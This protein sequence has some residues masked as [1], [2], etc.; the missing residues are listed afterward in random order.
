MFKNIEAFYKANHFK[1]IEDKSE[2]SLRP[3]KSF[4]KDVENCISKFKTFYIENEYRTINDERLTIVIGDVDTNTRSQNL[5]VMRE[6]GFLVEIDTP[7]E[8]GAK[9]K[10]TDSFAEFVDS[11]MSP[12]DVVFEKFR[13]LSS[14][15]NFTMY[16][17]LLLCTLR[18]AYVYGQVM[19]FR[20]SIDKFKADVPDE[21]KRY[22][23]RK[24][25]HDIYGYSG[26]DKQIT[27]DVYSPNLSYMS[28]AELENLGLLI[29][30]TQKIDNMNN[31]VLTKKGY[32][33]LQHIDANLGSVPST[34]VMSGNEY[35]RAAQYLRS[36]VSETG[37]DIPSKKDD[38]ESVLSEFNAKFS[39][40]TLAALPDEDILNYIFYTLGDNLESLCC[41]LEMNKEC[42]NHFG[43]IS[44]GSAYKFGLF[45]KQKT[46]EWTTGSPQKSQVLTEDEALELGCKIRDALVTAANIVKNATLDT[47]EDY[48]R[49]DD[50]LWEKVG[51]PYCNWGW[52]HKYLS[53]VCPDKLS[54]YH[55]SDWQRHVLYALKIKPSEKYFAR[56]GQLAMI[57][58]YAGWYYSEFKDVLVERFGSEILQF[59]RIGTSDDEQNY[60]SEWSQK[61]VFGIGWRDIGP[62]D[63]YVAGEGLDKGAIADALKEKFGYQDNIASRKA[64]ELIRFYKTDSSTV[65]VAMDGQSLL[66]FI[67]NIGEYFYDPTSAM[68][69]MKPGTWHR[70]FASGE[71]LPVKAEGKLTS[72][73]QLTDIENVMFLYDRYFYGSE[74]IIESVEELSFDNPEER[75]KRKFRSWMESQ[76]K[77]EG[78]SD[79]GQPYT[80]NSINQYVSNIA[81]TSLPSHQEHSVFFTNSIAE[82]QECITVL[83]NSDKKN[84]TQKSAVK[85]YLE[86]LTAMQEVN[87]PLQYKTDISAD[88]ERNR[89]VFGAPGTG[90]SFNLKRDCETFLKDT[91]GTYERVTFHPDYT[92]SQFV[93]TYKPVSDGVGIRYE[94]VPGPFMR[95]FVDAM[96]SAR[97]ASPQPHILIIEEINRAK[98]ASVFGDVFQLLDRDDDGVS[99]YEIQTS[100]DIRKHL[101]KELKCD[102]SQC[103]KIKIPNNM[104]IWATMNSADQGVFPMDTAFKR[105]WHFEY[106]GINEGQDKIKG[107]LS[108]GSTVIQAIEWNVLRRAINEKLAKEYKVN[109]DKLMGPFFI[110]K[111]VLKTVSE[112]DDT[113]VDPARFIEVFKSKVIMYLYEDAAKQYKHKLFSG[114]E[115]TTKYSAVCDSFDEIGIQI[116]GEDF[117]EVYYNSQKG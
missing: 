93:G 13:S 2:G 77:P 62:L 17:N 55:S 9:Y 112:T 49:L 41:W 33:L 114:C 1:L 19:L 5:R 28:R 106:L 10:F 51:E 44:G 39:P 30:T 117:V 94:F 47:I 20:D 3:G 84:N 113:L 83:E 4:T 66:A 57:E 91:S 96:K 45:Q 23:Y 70:N 14:L 24:R 75:N 87:M 27:D 34:P 103:Q 79:A 98:V 52:F 64:G 69:N 18:E 59:V 65:A 54:S 105:R 95:V 72:C 16:L 7:E 97:S 109:E 99:E 26:R 36:F 29:M 37:F 42:R 82:V 73:Y 40:D 100:E 63:D 35:E 110:S 21:Q 25:I 68:A 48:E 32:E 22:E 85:K 104:F 74:E 71:Q 15:E 53:M 67:D 101:A 8:D 89:I 111:N 56:S 46:G 11:G 115:D 102:I 60:A 58:N 76:V 116:F 92:Y 108:V 61:S 88:Y 43:S 78:D 80:A 86:F 38:I 6:F 50:E 107:I 12:R 81:N 31:L 90:K